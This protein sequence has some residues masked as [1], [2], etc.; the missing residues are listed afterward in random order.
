M[1]EHESKDEDYMAEASERTYKP[2]KK[3]I[4]ITNDV[5]KQLLENIIERH[6]SIKQV[7]LFLFLGS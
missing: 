4:K 6:M 3:Y 7:T 5:K 2:S 1:Q